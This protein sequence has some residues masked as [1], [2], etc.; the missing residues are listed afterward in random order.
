MWR[1][2]LSSHQAVCLYLTYPITGLF[3]IVSSNAQVERKAVEDLLGSVEDG[4]YKK[5]KYLMRRCG[6]RHLFYLCEGDF[7]H[8]Q[9]FAGDADRAERK[10]Q[11]IRNA[12]LT[13]ELRD[14]FQVTRVDKA[15]PREEG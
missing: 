6:L 5:Q 9:F 1:G 8:A 14:G 2:C 11:T 12:L 10:R 7:E 13:T 15:G 4:R 3:S